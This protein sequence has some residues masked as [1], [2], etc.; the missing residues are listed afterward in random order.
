MRNLCALGRELT[1][2]VVSDFLHASNGEKYFGVKSLQKCKGKH[3]IC[4]FDEKFACFSINYA[5][6][7]PHIADIHSTDASKQWN[8]ER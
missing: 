2:F 8:I 5:S 7:P 1:A 3:E 4:K 6:L